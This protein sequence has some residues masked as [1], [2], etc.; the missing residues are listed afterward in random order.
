MSKVWQ[1]T[2]RTGSL[3][4]LSLILTGCKEEIA[5]PS[6]QSKTVQN[7]AVLNQNGQT[8]KALPK[9]SLQT[10][11]ETQTVPTIR[12]VGEIQSA[13]QVDMSVNFSAPVSH[14]AVTEGQRV[15]RNQLLLELDATKLQLHLNAA[16]QALQQ[17]ESRLAEAANNLQRREVLANQNNLSQEALDSAHYE[18][19]RSQAEVAEARANVSLAQRELSDTRLLS[20]VDGIV[21]KQLVEAGESVQPGQKLLILQATETL[22]VQTF[23]SDHNVNSLAPGS[24][25]EVSINKGW[26]ERSYQA[27]ILSI[28]AAADSRTGNFEIRLLLNQPDT[29]IRP[30][31]TARISME[32]LPLNG[33][34]LL[35][36]SAL[37]DQQNQ[38]VVFVYNEL[39][40]KVEQRYPALKVGLGDQLIIMSGLVAGEQVVVGGVKHLVEGTEVDVAD[41]A[42]NEISQLSVQ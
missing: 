7:E 25:A 4:A 42:N 22:E 2:K 41:R 5:Q 26:Q 3:I 31:M 27:E 12:T 16:K 1:L 36:E 20:P 19:Q 11:V 9:V 30:G 23:V 28:G 24:R 34:L 13:V 35:P 29:Y 14:I 17:A 32:G 8:D 21:D 33:I 40:G 38:R 15:K 39:T 37:T 6:I 10:M 18:H